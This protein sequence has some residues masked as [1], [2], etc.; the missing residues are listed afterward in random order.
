MR[1]R[2]ME[3]QQHP[4]QRGLWGRPALF[5][6]RLEHL[7]QGRRGG[8]RERP[9]CR[10]D[11]CQVAKAAAPE[12]AAW[13]KQ[14]QVRAV[15]QAEVRGSDTGGRVAP[16]PPSEPQPV[17]VMRQCG[18]LFSP[19]QEELARRL[20]NQMKVQV[21]N[22]QAAGRKRRK[23][24]RQMKAARSKHISNNDRGRMTTLQG[25]LR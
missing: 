25:N 23:V 7:L 10:A 12:A 14:A 17:G 9:R 2:G 11:A 1:F 5:S 18:G 16:E 15:L 4:Q 13:G 24:Q 19:R 6:P 22:K 8:W 21:S 20:M 3:C